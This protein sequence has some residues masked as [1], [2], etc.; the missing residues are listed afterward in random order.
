MQFDY[1]VSVTNLAEAFATVIGVLL[2]FQ[3]INI[4]VA[5]IRE[6]VKKLADIPSIIGRHDERLK[7]LEKDR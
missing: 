5:F 6:E 3:R 2:A 1:T 4:H 7:H